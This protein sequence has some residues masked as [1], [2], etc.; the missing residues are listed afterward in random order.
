MFF[1]FKGETEDLQMARK[2]DTHLA[3]GLQFL[4]GVSDGSTKLALRN[5]LRGKAMGLPSGEVLAR[6]LGRQPLSREELELEQD[7]PLWYY[8]LREADILGEGENL[9]P[10]GSTIVAETMLGMLN[11]DPFSFLRTDPTWEPVIPQTTHGRVG[12]RR[13]ARLRRPE[14][15]PPAAAARGPVVAQTPEP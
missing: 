1:E 12:H 4:P 14:R 5:L 8:I 13:P 10:V 3:G 15:R 2:I 9:G 11:A 7:A 6:R